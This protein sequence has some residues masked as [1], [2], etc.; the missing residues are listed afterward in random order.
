MADNPIEAVGE[1]VSDHLDEIKKLFKPPTK[2][3]VMVMAANDPDGLKDF[4]MGDDD[5]QGFMN[6]LARR[7]AAGKS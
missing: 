7:M 6:M 3:L 5:L 4:A 2:I 1:V